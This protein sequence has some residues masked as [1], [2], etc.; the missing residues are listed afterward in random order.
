MSGSLSTWTIYDH[1]SDFPDNYVVREFRIQAGSDPILGQAH[2]FLTLAEA[3]DALQQLAPS[4]YCL[5]RQPEDDPTVV[6][7]WL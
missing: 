2:L 5:A 3:R 4:A 6:E 1:P 7:T